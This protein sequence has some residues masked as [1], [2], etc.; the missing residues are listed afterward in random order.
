MYSLGLPG[1]FGVGAESMNAIIAAAIGYS[2][3]NLNRS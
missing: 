1:Q 2:D 3:A